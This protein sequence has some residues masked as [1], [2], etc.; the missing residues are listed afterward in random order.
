MMRP[1]ATAMV[2]PSRHTGT[3]MSS[4]SSCKALYMKLD[5]LSG[6]QTTWLTPHFLS[7]S[8]TLWACKAAG[9]GAIAPRGPLVTIVLLLSPMSLAALILP[10]IP[11]L[12]KTHPAALKAFLD[13]LGVGS[14]NATIR[15][16]SPNQRDTSKGMFRVVH[17]GI[18]ALGVQIV[19]AASRREGIQIVGAI[20]TD[21]ALVG[22]DLGEVAQTGRTLGITVSS[23]AAGVLREIPA[24]VVLHTTSSF[25]PQVKDQLLG[26]MA[27]GRN[28]VSTCE[29]LAFPAAQHPALAHELDAAARAAGVTL[30][31]TGINPG[32]LM[33]FLPVTLSS[34]CQEVRS[35]SVTRVADASQRRLPLQKKIGAGMTVPEF[36]AK[37]ADG[38]MGH[39]GL[40]ESV[41]LIAT[42][43]GWKLD[44]TETT[45]EPEIA[46]EDVVTRYLEVKAG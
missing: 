29:E 24:D 37:A 4:G 12:V 2:S 3:R 15:A 28:V 10:L 6:S 21:P 33:D 9:S 35:I 40:I 39:I 14:N 42:A 32:F 27:A 5:S 26:I 1:A 20:D 19:S 38:A 25:L 23:D 46:Q 13:S 34:I 45:L 7:S 43:L 36:K 22:K 11:G 41:A 44:R 30:L 17:Y 18:G 16:F 31:G 8:A